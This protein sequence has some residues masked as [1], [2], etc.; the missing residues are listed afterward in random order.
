MWVCVWFLYLTYQK[1]SI[2]YFNK[3]SQKKK[4]IAKKHYTRYTIFQARYCAPPFAIWISLLN[5]A[6]RRTGE[7][8]AHRQA[9]P[10][11]DQIR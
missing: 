1:S 4:K 10:F 3:N 7:E 6:H 2:S 9:G 8:K 11:Y 5:M